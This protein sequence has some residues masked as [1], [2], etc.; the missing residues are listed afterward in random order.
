MPT[1][2]AAVRVAAGRAPDRRAGWIGQPLMMGTPGPIPLVRRERPSAQVA[3]MVE[4][5]P[6]SPGHL[7]N[8]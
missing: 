8:A 1:A 3:G 4:N 7:D 5:R 2:I 6:D